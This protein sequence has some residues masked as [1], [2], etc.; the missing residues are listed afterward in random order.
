MSVVDDLVALGAFA[1]GAAVASLSWWLLRRGGEP[2]PPAVRTPPAM[3]P[4]VTPRL[5]SDS[6]DPDGHGASAVPSRP[7]DPA[8]RTS[9]RVVLHLAAQPRLAYG[10]VAP[11]EIT[12]AGMSRALHLAQP[13]LARVL[14]RLKDGDALLEMRTHVS[15]QP[16]R[17]KVYQLTVH[18]EAIARDLRI[19]RKDPAPSHRPSSVPTGTGPGPG[20]GG[21][22]AVAEA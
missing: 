18:G 22:A 15:G 3:G 14:G 19:R 21:A 5:P 16:R 1:T 8:L 7:P 9:Q 11:F 20:S 17:L 4:P 2:E 12:Q 13:A 10:D 6:E